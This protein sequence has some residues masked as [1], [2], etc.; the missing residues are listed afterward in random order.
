LCVFSPR[1]LSFLF[2]GTEAIPFFR[3]ISAKPCAPHD[4]TTS[5]LYLFALPPPLPLGFIT[6]AHAER[7]REALTDTQGQPQDTHRPACRFLHCPS[8]SVS[9]SLSLFSF[10]RTT[11][12]S[13][14]QISCH[15]RSVIINTCIAEPPMHGFKF[16][17]SVMFDAN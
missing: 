17:T 9:L 2:L 3:K 1:I 6:T 8:A 12:A 7:E 10:Y 11:T 5:S 13:L 4:A 14:P 16:C 15:V